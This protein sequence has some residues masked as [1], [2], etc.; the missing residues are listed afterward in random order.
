MDIIHDEIV[1]FL[2][3]RIGCLQLGKIRRGHDLLAG[4]R[5]IAIL[6]LQM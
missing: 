2:Q 1:F 4:C 3:G 5:P 6:I